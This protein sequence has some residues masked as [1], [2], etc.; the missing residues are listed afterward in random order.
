MVNSS[1]KNLKIEMI[2]KMVRALFILA[3]YINE[4]SNTSPKIRVS[5]R[6]YKYV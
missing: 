1:L 2:G 4:K 3:Y 5:K 6:T